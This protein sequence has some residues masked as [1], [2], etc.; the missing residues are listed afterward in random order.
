[1]FVIKIDTDVDYCKPLLDDVV[2]VKNIFRGLDNNNDDDDGD[3]DDDYDDDEQAGYKTTFASAV[4]SGWQP[5]RGIFAGVTH[6]TTTTTT[7]TTSA[8]SMSSRLAA[9]LP[10]G[11]QGSRRWW[12]SM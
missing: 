9:L 10:D 7:I 8:L 3:Y 2:V 4:A 11:D 6:R 12:G 1:M 5:E